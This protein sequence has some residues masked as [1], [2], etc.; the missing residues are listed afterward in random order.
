ITS[1]LAGPLA[2][3]R[4]VI[5]VTG[6]LTKGRLRMAP[7]PVAPA[8]PP[9]GPD[10]RAHGI[11]N[12]G[13]VHRNLPPAALTEHALLRGEATLTGPG[14]LVAY[15]AKRTGRSPQDRFVVAGPSSEPDV[16]WGAVNRPMEQAA[17]DRLLDKALAYFQGRDLFVFD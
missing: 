15:P 10:L 17:F 16:S 6:R 4:G 13:A 2:A 8:A 3:S 11:L 9:T 1:P 12:P 7:A 14:A 5:R